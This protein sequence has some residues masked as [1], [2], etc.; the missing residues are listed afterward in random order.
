MAR[1]GLRYATR[2]QALVATVT[3]TCIAPEAHAEPRAASQMVDPKVALEAPANTR[4]IVVEGAIAMTIDTDCHLSSERCQ[5]R[6]I[7]VPAA[8]TGVQI[9]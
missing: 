2:T 6:M 3:I 1:A 4:E 7:I 9:C 5:Q 8:S